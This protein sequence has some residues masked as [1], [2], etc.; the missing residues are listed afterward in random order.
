MEEDDTDVAIVASVAG[1][2]LARLGREAL[3]HL[4][5]QAIM[6]A[7]QGDAIS[8]QAWSDIAD[9]AQNLLSSN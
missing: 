1:D 6:A 5:D 3:P 7:G 9:A 2:Y 8:A 4:R